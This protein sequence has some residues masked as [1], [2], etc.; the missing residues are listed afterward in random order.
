[1]LYGKT[2]AEIRQEIQPA[3]KEKKSFRIYND[4]LD[5][6]FKYSWMLVSAGIFYKKEDLRE[7]INGERAKIFVDSG[8]Y[9]LAKGT[10]PAETYTDKV[11]LEWSEKNGDIFPILDRPSFN[12]GPDKPLKSYDECLAKT[13]TS[14]KYYTENRTRSDVKVLN[15]LQGQT[16]D[17]MEKWYD[18]VKDFKLDGWGIGGTQGHINRILTALILLLNKGE[19]KDS[20]YIHIFGVS[21]NEI[22]LLLNWTQKIL[23]EMDVD[24]Q[25]TYDATSWNRAAVFGQYFTESSLGVGIDLKFNNDFRLPCDCV[26][27]VDI[28]NTYDLFNTKSNK[29]ISFSNFNHLVGFHNLYMQLRYIDVVNNLLEQERSYLKSVLDCNK[30]NKKITIWDKM[31]RIESGLK[32]QNSLVNMNI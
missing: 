7:K 15:V 6:Y 4:S 24:I 3:M 12:T 2:D 23:G 11:A 19:L 22:I 26:V 9:Q 1:M 20:K 5:T 25:L 21:S 13:I 17:A 29:K 10:V 14:A 31:Q 18:H 30:Y 27:C 28:E 8:G 32:T 16:K